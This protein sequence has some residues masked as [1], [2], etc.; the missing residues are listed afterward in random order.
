[1]LGAVAV[2]VKTPE[3]SP[4]K[5]RLAKTVGREKADMF[6]DLS[7]QAIE[8]VVLQA[9]KLTDGKLQAYWAVGEEQGMESPRWQNLPCVH[10]GEGGLGQR[11]HH[12]YSTLL[13]Q[14]DYVLLLGADSPQ[15]SPQHLINAAEFLEKEDKFIIGPASDG[16]FYLFGGKKEIAEEVWTSVPYS[17]RDTLEMLQMKLGLDADEGMSSFE[18]L[19]DVDTEEDLK[20]LLLQMGGDKLPMQQRLYAWLESYK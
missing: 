11:L 14:H 3:L 1:M 19:L 9:N 5:T 12:V 16:G 4:V 8:E 20:R 7:V 15:L 13:K 18:T 10:T 17:A 2:F 6:F